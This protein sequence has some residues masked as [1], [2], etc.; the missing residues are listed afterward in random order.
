[1]FKYII[2]RKFSH[3]YYV[4]DPRKNW[5]HL[6]KKNWKSNITHKMNTQLISI[7]AKTYITLFDNWDLF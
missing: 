1:M 3:I 5:P 2:L 4:L 7:I 6:K